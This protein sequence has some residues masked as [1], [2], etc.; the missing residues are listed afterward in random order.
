MADQLDENYTEEAKERPGFLTVI[1]VLSFIATG[2]GFLSGLAS[3]IR[4]KQSEEQMLEGKVAITK[5]ISDLKKIGM[6]GFV[7]FM[8]KTQA[9]SV[10]INNSF[11]LA[12]AIALFVSALGAF[13]VYKMFMGYKL[14]FHIYIIYCLVSVASL[15]IY[16]APANIPSFL[17]IFNLIISAIFIFMY[18][19]NLHWMNK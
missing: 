6:D 10:D 4:G 14:G 17:I 19:R 13:G 3:L 16:I 9:M 18:S 12:T 2:I 1:C 15:Y 11:Y 5:S 7:D 8:E